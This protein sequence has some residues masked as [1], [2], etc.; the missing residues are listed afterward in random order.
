MELRDFLLSIIGSGAA[1][2]GAVFVLL[3]KITAF[4]ALDPETKRWVVMLLSGVLG[5]VAWG[6]ALFLGYIPA[7]EVYTTNF[8]AESIW[9]YG[10]MTGFVAFTSATLI[11]GRVALGNTK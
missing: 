3:N 11:H 9:K 4:D 10:V 6:A 1:I 8:Y 2:G 5:I 7:P